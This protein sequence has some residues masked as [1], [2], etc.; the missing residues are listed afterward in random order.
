MFK[1]ILQQQQKS[2]LLGLRRSRT[3]LMDRCSPTVG[4]RFD[5]YT[6]EGVGRQLC[7][8][9]KVRVRGP[10]TWKGG[11]SVRGQSV[12]AFCYYLFLLRCVWVNNLIK[13]LLNKH[14]CI[15]C[16]YNYVIKFWI[17]SSGTFLSQ[18]TPEAVL[19]HFIHPLKS[20]G[21]HLFHVI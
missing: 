8:V 18:I 9:T 11:G 10:I 19:L 1:I 6:L 20:Y 5:K 2:F 7:N 21:L 13:R 4:L 12:F 17:S 16:F 3:Q 15:S 14:L